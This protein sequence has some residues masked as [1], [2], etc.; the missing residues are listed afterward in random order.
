MVSGVTDAH[1]IDMGNTSMLVSVV[2]PT[3]PERRTVG[4]CDL[5]LYEKEFVRINGELYHAAFVVP[6]TLVGDLLQKLAEIKRI[7]MKL[8]QEVYTLMVANNVLNIIRNT[9]NAN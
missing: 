8:E 7:K 9:K 2:D 4:E 1:R 5:K 3:N 6:E